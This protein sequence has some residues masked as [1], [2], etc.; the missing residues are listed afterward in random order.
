MC[1]K[2]PAKKG[3]LH[4]QAT[5][6]RMF[7]KH[8]LTMDKVKQFRENSCRYPH[9]LEH[10]YEFPALKILIQQSLCLHPAG[11]HINSCRIHLVAYKQQSNSSCSR[12]KQ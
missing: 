12:L 7:D 6:A 1:S 2:G 5:K 11:L 8:K 4:H 10:Q 3:C 9:S